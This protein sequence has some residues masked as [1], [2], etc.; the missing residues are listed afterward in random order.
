[1]T[2]SICVY[3]RAL[4]KCQPPRLARNHS[5][6]ALDLTEVLIHIVLDEVLDEGSFAH[7]R[8]TVNYHNKGWGFFGCCVHNRHCTQESVYIAD[9]VIRTESSELV[10]IGSMSAHK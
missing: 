3:L 9:Q 1:M 2:A 6:R 8:G 5:D 10:A 7:P 4:Y